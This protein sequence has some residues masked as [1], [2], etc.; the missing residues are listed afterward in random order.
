MTCSNAIVVARKGTI[1]GADTW[2]DIAAAC[3]R[4]AWLR[5][6]AARVARDTFVAACSPMLDP[7]EIGRS[8]RSSGSATWVVN[9]HRHRWQDLAWLRWRQGRR[10]Q[11]PLLLVS[12]WASETRLTPGRLPSRLE[13]Q[14]DHG[15]PP[16]C[17]SCRGS[18]VARS[19]STRWAAKRTSPPR[20]SRAA[21]TTCWHSRAIT[22]VCAAVNETF[23]A[24]LEADVLADSGMSRHVT[25]ET[26]RDVVHTAKRR[27]RRR[28][29]VAARRRRLARLGYADRWCCDGHPSRS[30]ASCADRCPHQPATET[31]P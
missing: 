27:G 1:A 16:C 9:L 31:V 14:R 10:P 30:A 7:I 21:A 4:L 26:N 2:A 29:Q 24:A 11:C 15:G 13:V 18:S 28:L 17:W 6:P 12:A 23:T 20:S 8:H 19:P 25:T 22:K 5:T 3:A